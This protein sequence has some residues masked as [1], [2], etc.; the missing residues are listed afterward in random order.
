MKTKIPDN[1]IA[2]YDG[3]SVKLPAAT[4]Y[5]HGDIKLS[6]KQEDQKLNISVKADVTALRF[7]RMRWNFD[8]AD[9]PCGSVKVLG[10]AWER[11]YGELNWS[12]INPERALPW[13]T[14]ITNAGS[15]SGHTSAF[16]VMVRPSA[17]CFWYLDEGGITLWMDIRCGGTGVKL[18]GRTLDAAA[19]LFR[20]YYQYT[21]YEAGRKFCSEMC[22]DPLPL[23]E[24][25]YGAN[26]WYYAY[27]SNNAAGILRDAA[28]TAGLTKGLKNRPFA[29]IDMGWDDNCEN[30]MG[31]WTCTNK[32][33]PDM[34]RLAEEMTALD[35]KPGIWVRPLLDMSRNIS[36][37]EM[38]YRLKGNPEVLD[39][40]HPVI[41]DRI[42][43]IM[44]R[45]T[46]EWGYKLVKY[47]YAT[48]DIVGRWGFQCADTLAGNDVWSFYD[49]TLTT[50]EIITNLYRTIF[51]SAVDAVLIGCNTVSHL[52]AGLVHV[53]RT[54]DDTSGL[55]WDRTR[56]MGVNTL[57][58]RMMQNKTFYASDADCVGITEKVS[59]GLTS[60]W[61]H[62]LSNSGTPL[63]ISLKPGILN[64]EQLEELRE[65]YKTASGQTD[66]LI[67]LNWTDSCCPSEWLLNGRQIHYDWNDEF[68]PSC[69]TPAL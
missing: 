26:D 42:K 1:I 21:A 65:A 9:M 34:K 43:Q 14:L 4:G 54:G 17:F 55:E 41:L 11:G 61:L 32:G 38:Q 15:G 66:V 69:F 6:F 3:G 57:A 7:L 56:K 37:D 52:C 5:S 53:N 8:K 40:S 12:S 29:V 19:V 33:F 44:K 68:G 16:G 28:F 24:P 58:F 64:D 63:F 23:D 45:M 31:P 50:A 10:D 47:D 18:N 27:G 20:D 22:T 25:V 62:I 35:V 13:Y 67:P 48:F 49:K 51:E 39:P 46:E 59:W 36:P 2:Y 30:G 60:K